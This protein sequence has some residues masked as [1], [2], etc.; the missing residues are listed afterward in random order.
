MRF[1]SYE[2]PSKAV[3]KS[4]GME[5]LKFKAREKLTKK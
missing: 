2:P 5:C 4:S 3:L 1:K